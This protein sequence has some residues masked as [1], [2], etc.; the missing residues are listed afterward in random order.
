MC[1]V[2]SKDGKKKCGLNLCCSYY[3]WCGTNTTHCGNKDE[4]GFDTP[5]QKGFGK[6]ELVKPPSCGKDSGSA[7]NGRRIAYYQSWNT[8]QRPCNRIWPDQINTAGLTHMNFAFASIDPET[9]RIRPMH[10]DDVDLYRRFTALQSPKLQTWIAVGGWD[11]SDVGPTHE[12]WSK[13]ASTKENRAAFVDSALQFMKEYGFQGLDIDWEYPVAADRGGSEGDT[14]NLVSLVIE[15]R[16]TFGKSFGLSSILAPD[17]WYL[18]NMDPKAMEAQVDWFNFMAYDLHG[19]WD[20]NTPGLGNKIRPHTDLREI[21]KD[22]LPLWYNELNPKK[23][24]LGVAYYGRGYTASD[25]KCLQ[26]GCEFSGPSAASNCTKA[27]GLLSN[28]EISRLIKDKNLKPELMKDAAVKQIAWDDQWIG[29]DDDETHNMKLAHANERCL[30][31]SFIW[32][33]DFGSGSG[34]G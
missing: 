10:P 3:G 33:I 11:F 22:L 1:G 25:K 15:L 8:R 24:N 17:F 30:G 16:K 2:D 32:S 21:E 27:P 14:A 9:F 19:A 6:C 29:Y 12:T 28:H 18:S 26:F 7:S 5:C 34:T 23:V 13:M 4:H 20:Q 31:G